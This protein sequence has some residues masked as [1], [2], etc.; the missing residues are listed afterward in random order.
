MS[1]VDEILLT[2]AIS[3]ALVAVLLIVIVGP[4]RMATAIREIRPR[5][6]TVAPYIGVMVAVLTGR[7]LTQ[8][9]AHELTMF[10]D[11]DVTWI[12]FGIEGGFVGQLQRI[13]TPELSAYFVFMYIFGYVVLIAF[14]ALAYFCLSPLTHLKELLSAYIIND[15]VGISI[16]IAVIALGPRNL[17]RG[18]AEPLLY[19]IY[20][21]AAILTGTVNVPINV[22]PSLHTSMAATVMLFAWRTR[23]IFPVWSVI[24]VIYGISIIFST[25]YLGIHW[26]IDVLAGGLLAV[27]AYYVSIAIVRRESIIVNRVAFIIPTR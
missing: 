9:H 20:P 18:L 22:F 14:P 26:F 19:D 1:L 16:Y 12:I 3:A 5:L 27:F 10:L 7:A 17:G 2:T 11:V 15:V 6:W 21:N 13:A 4:E 25:M 24:A 23:Q 8:E